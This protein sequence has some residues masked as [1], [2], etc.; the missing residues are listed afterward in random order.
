MLITPDW[1]DAEGKGLVENVTDYTYDGSIQSEEDIHIVLKPKNFIIKGSLE[2]NGS[3]IADRSFIVGGELVVKG[4]LFVTEELFVQKNVHVRGDFVGGWN[5][6]VC[7]VFLVDGHIKSGGNVL[8]E[9]RITCRK[10]LRF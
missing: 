4:N 8:S 7:G 3:I 2:S 1:K 5:A 6:T 9:K 10:F